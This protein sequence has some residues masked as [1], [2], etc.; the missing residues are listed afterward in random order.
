MFRSYDHLQVEINMLISD[1]NILIACYYFTQIIRYMFRLYDH[2]QAKIFT[3]VVN[4]LT[5]ETCSE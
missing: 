2:L 5:T 3:S 4:M 1:V